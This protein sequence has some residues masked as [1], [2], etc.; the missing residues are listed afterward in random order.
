M[1]LLDTYILELV[2]SLSIE[3][4]DSLLCI[5]NCEIV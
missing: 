2:P 5:A 3:K 1:T 4:S